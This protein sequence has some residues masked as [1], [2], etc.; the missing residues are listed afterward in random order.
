VLGG[1]ADERAGV[2]AAVLTRPELA[3]DLVAGEQARVGR[4]DDDQR[5]VLRDPLA[6]AEQTLVESGRR[7]AVV[8]VELELG[9]AAPELRLG[10]E[11]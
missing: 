8:R 7:D 9:G 1:V 10:P 5:A 4:H 6:P 11:V 2:Q 3:Q